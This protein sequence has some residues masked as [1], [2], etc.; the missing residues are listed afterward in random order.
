MT[1]YLLTTAA[2]LALMA[3]GVAIA[4][5]HAADHAVDHAVEQPATEAGHY[6]EA[7]DADKDGTVSAEELA[8]YEA[9]KAAEAANGAAE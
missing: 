6:L 5:E 7:A 4:D 3:G 1:K 2:V 9:A 8:A